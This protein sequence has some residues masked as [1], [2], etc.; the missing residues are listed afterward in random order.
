MARHRIIYFE[1][2]ENERT[3]AAILDAAIDEQDRRSGRLI[4]P[5]NRP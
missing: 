3:F 4:V 2:P 1:T 5:A